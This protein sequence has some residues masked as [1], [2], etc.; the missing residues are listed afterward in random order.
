MVCGLEPLKNV[1]TELTTYTQKW[2]LYTAH[3]QS[4]CI[5]VV[6]REDDT[7]RLALVY[8]K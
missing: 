2:Q 3:S 6:N 7:L 4:L 8:R 5:Q 1:H